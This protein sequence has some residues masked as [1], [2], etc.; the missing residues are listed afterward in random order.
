MNKD[1]MIDVKN[2]SKTKL[3]STLA[4]I[5]S[6]LVG[7][8][9]FTIASF[10]IL[11]LRNMALEVDS[12]ASAV[13]KS[14][15][16]ALFQI[17]GPAVEH[18]KYNRIDKVIVNA[19][20]NNLIAYFIVKN[21]KTKNIDYSSISVLTNKKFSQKLIDSISIDRNR[22]IK[23]NDDASTYYI[24]GEKENYT[25][26]LGFYSKSFILQEVELFINSM[27]YLVFLA[28]FN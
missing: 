14:V 19:K 22:N 4:L 15:A 3:G 1:N 13:N 26:Y 27:S 5:S 18:K 2:F 28:I 24:V 6:V 23:L 8:V 10:T 16:T 25:M 9:A 11:F 17:L 7:I 12:Q 21:N 20:T